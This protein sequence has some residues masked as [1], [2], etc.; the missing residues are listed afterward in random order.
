VQTVKNDI[1]LVTG[2]LGFIGKYFVRRCLASGHFVRNIDKVGYAADHAVNAEFGGFPNYRF[3]NADIR[4]LDFLPECDVIVNFAAESHVDNAISNSRNFCTT[5]FLGVQN[6]LELTRHKM[7]A[8]RPRF[9]QIST[10]EVYGDITKGAHGENAM[11]VPSNPY[12]ATKAAADMLVKSWGRTYGITW[13]IVRPTNNYGLHQYPEKLIPK[14]TWRMKRG[15]PAIMH[16]DGSYVRSWLHTEDTV[17]A[18]LTVIEK[19][20]V[21]RIYNIGSD[22]ELR[23]IDVL[24]AIAKLLDVPEQKAWISIE[25][26][27]GQDIRYS[28]DDKPLRALGWRPRRQFV[29]ELPTI[30]SSLDVSRFS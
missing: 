26:R 23:N 6:L 13:N 5:N 10:D 19:G 11:L 9:I 12:A 3:I 14:S 2:G 25:D 8:E 17:D 20:E 21:N 18:L 30:V 28:L 4:D 29:D 16:G 1:I 7:V 24:R 15:V 27:S 22:T